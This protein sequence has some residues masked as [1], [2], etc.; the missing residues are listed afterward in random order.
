MSAVARFSWSVAASAMYHTLRVG[1]LAR[2]R[3][4]DEGGLELIRGDAPLVIAANHQSHSDTA[5]L[6]GALPRR[7]RARVRFVASGIRFAPA[8]PGA[9]LRER[10]ERWLLNGLAIH[11]YRSILVGGAV[12][13][14]RALDELAD[15]LR[16][17]T[18]IAIYPEGTRS[19]DGHL[20]VLKPGVAML[21]IE[22]GCAIVPVRIDGTR[23]ALPKSIRLPR[24]RSQV[25]VRFRTPILAQPNES[26]AAL[27]ARVAE[28]LAPAV[29]R[30]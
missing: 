5:V 3:A 6:H 8:I 25:C 11:A 2:V 27:I 29:G 26:H 15:A 9:P 19:R 10:A 4:I 18:S 17:G 7:R 24:L 14:L 1:T 21:A 23:E 13:G 28:A 16:E 22:T 30:T 12:N 20:G